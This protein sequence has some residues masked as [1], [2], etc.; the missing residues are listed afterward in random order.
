M[1]FNGSVSKLKKK[2]VS[3]ITAVVLVNLV[4]LGG[5]TPKQLK[6]AKQKD[7]G[8]KEEF[9]FAIG[10]EPDTGFD[11]T[12]GWGRYGSPFFQSTL[13]KRDDQLKIV[14]DLA[15]GYEISPDGKTWTVTIRDDANFSDGEPVKA[16][17]VKFTFETIIENGSVV[18]LNEIE[19]IQVIDKKIVEFTLKESQSTFVNNLVVTGIVPEHVYDEDYATKPVGSGP[20]QFVQ[21]D[22][23]QQLIVE[24]NPEYYG[25]KPHLKKITFLFLNETAAFAAAQADQVDLIYLPAAFS[26]KKVSGM[27]LEVVATVDNRGIVFPFVKSGNKTAQGDLIGNDVTADRAIRQ[28]IN[29]GIDRKALIEGALEG[30]GTPAYTSVDGLPWWNSDTV[31]ADGDLEGAKKILKEAGWEDQDGD[32]ILEKGSLKAEFELYYLADDELRQSLAIAV[33]DMVK[34]LGI[35]LNIVAGSW[36]IIGKK[37]H[38]EAV[39]MGWGSHDPHEMYNIYGGENRGVEYFNTGYYQNQTVDSYFK[40]A[41]QAKTEDEAL[42]FWQKAQWDGVTGYSTKGDAAWAWLVNIEHLYLVKEELDIGVQRTHVHGHGWPITD[43]IVDW[44]WQD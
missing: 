3:L 39:L 5:C 7:E 8:H 19:Q 33:A 38:S 13:L 21:W 25:K 16:S 6:G 28:A 4:I 23:G 44:K 32:Q 31:V 37:M 30:R 41:L 24:E 12:L 43:N 10:S 1:K 2:L 20:Y 15:T 29:L 40:K 42:E 22:R 27:R 9:V 14:N 35:K 18:D 34:P 36:D 17:D 26:K 11:P